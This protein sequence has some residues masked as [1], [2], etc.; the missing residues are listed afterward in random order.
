MGEIRVSDYAH[1]QMEAVADQELARILLDEKVCACS[2][3]FG[4][5]IS[6]SL[7]KL[8]PRYAHP[9]KKGSEKKII[10]EMRTEL[11]EAI[12]PAI[13]LVSGRT[14]HPERPIVT[15]DVRTREY[16]VQNSSERAVLAALKEATNALPDLC[17][18]DT[19]MSFVLCRA[20]NELPPRYVSTA[21]GE[22]YAKADHLDHKLSTQLLV[23]IIRSFECARER[24]HG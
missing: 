3:C 23:S 15:R 9:N 18:C 6:L 14:R 12:F 20:L 21:K 16:S 8:P 24:N 5:M 10:E 4:D 19:C 17:T 13:K 11:M 2:L 1:N 22:I 7:T